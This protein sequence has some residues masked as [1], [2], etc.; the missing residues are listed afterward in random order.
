MGKSQRD[1]GARGEREFAKLIGGEKIPLSGAVKGFANDVR[2]EL[3]GMD[4]EV[5][6]RDRDSYK[7]LY[8][9]LA[10]KEGKNPPDALALRADYHDWLIVIPYERLR[11]FIKA[12][13]SKEMVK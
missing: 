7:T 4:F 3:W 9:L 2:Y 10:G 1:K 13:Q 12:L 5:K 11:E 8:K 6:R